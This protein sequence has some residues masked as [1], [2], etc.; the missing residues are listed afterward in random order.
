[1]AKLIKAKVTRV[2]GPRKGTIHTRYFKSQNDLYKFLANQ[3]KAL[4]KKRN[5]K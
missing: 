4:L 5:K 2:R 3:R 1:M